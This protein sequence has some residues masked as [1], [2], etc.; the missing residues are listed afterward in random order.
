MVISGEKMSAIQRS[1]PIQ[2]ITMIV[3][4]LKIDL[5]MNV[6]VEIVAPDHLLFSARLK[7]LAIYWGGGGLAGFQKIAIIFGSL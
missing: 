1:T 7:I 3:K 4:S 2:R 6:T 5:K